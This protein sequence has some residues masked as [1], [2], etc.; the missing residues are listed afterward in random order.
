MRWTSW[1]SVVSRWAA[2][3][4]PT[5]RSEGPDQLPPDLGLGR[6]GSPP[7]GPY[8][9]STAIA[10]RSVA[11]TAARAVGGVVNDHLGGVPEKDVKPGQFLLG[12]QSGRLQ[13]AGRRDQRGAV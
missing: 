2:W 6:D 5:P 10:A 3:A 7:A 4:G 11:R 9:S 8:G 13:Q 1:S 12:D